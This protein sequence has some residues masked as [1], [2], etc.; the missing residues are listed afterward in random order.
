MAKVQKGKDE[1]NRPSS[2]KHFARTQGGAKS[3]LTE[4]YK[5]G[6]KVEALM[7]KLAGYMAEGA[8][9]D[10]TSDHQN[11]N[12]EPLPLPTPVV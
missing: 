11:Q 2:G 1:Y 3:Q 5:A 7:K 10:G 8:F 6:K 9:D 12:N 4:D